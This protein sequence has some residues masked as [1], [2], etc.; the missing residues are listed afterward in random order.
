MWLTYDS[1]HGIHALLLTLRGGEEGE[2]N[3][4]LKCHV[5][6]I[7]T[8]MSTYNVKI[9]SCIISFLSSE[10]LSYYYYQFLKGK[11]KDGGGTIPFK[12]KS[13]RHL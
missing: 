13:D 7:H 9:Q 4:M 12:G 6:K 2:T 10:T 1:L 11:V 5:R 3:L 8:I